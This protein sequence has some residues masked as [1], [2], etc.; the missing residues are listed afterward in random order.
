MPTNLISPSQKSYAVLWDLDGTLI[1]TNLFH[2][3]AWQEELA[4]LGRVLS[5]EEFST[6]FGQRNDTILRLW[7]DPAISIDEIQRISNSKE[8]RYRRLIIAS[9][10]QLLPGARHWLTELREAGWR[11]ALATMTGRENIATIFSVLPID[12]YFDAV[13]TGDDVTSG[14][15]DPEIFLQAARRVNVQPENCI[16]LEDAPAGVEAARRAGMKSIGIN[17]QKKLLADWHVQSL[18]LLPPN[19]FQSL[20]NKE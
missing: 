20:L 4:K 14:K 13:V 8:E 9:G 5:K 2:W 3:Q 16:V 18:E 15:P 17:S 19:I 6:S 1:D 7:I 10:L 12:T 11:Q